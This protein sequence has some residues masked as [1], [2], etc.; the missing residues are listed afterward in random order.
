MSRALVTGASRGIG[1]AIAKALARAGHHVIVNYRSQRAEAEQVCAAIEA[2][3]GRATPIGFDVRER[4]AVEAALAGLQQD[5]EPIDIL[6][7]NAGMTKDK[8]FPAIPFD[9]WDA[10]T[11]TTLDGFYNVT[12]PLVMP[13]V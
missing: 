9:D 13:M 5:P 4:T 7:N 12:Q 3:G 6:V 10:V 8:P 1:A 2:E 11:R